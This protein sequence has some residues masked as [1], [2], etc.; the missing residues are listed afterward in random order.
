M[1]VIKNIPA[2]KEDGSIY[3]GDSGSAVEEIQTFLQTL[4]YITKQQELL[5]DM[6]I[7]GTPE[8]LT[9][10]KH[11]GQYDIE[12]RK[13]IRDYQ[14][15]N[16]DRIKKAGNLSDDE[17]TKME[18]SAIITYATG[19][20]L[21]EDMGK[22]VKP[23]EETK[24]KHDEEAVKADDPVPEPDTVA[25][26]PDSTFFVKTKNLQHR[27]A[28]RKAPAWVKVSKEAYEDEDKKGVRVDMM[29]NGTLLKVV[30]PHTGYQCEWHQVL[31]VD[32]DPKWDSVKELQKTQ[33]LYCY[34]EFV[35]GRPGTPP[36]PAIECMNCPEIVPDADRKEPFRDWTKIIEPE[37]NPFY[38]EPT[39]RW[40]IVVE[41]QQENTMEVELQEQRKLASFE[42]VRMLLEFFDK[43]SGKDVIDG[44]LQY[45]N[46]VED[47]DY[48][49][50]ERPGSRIK[51]LVGLPA[52][53]FNAVPRNPEYFEGI[54]TLG[55]IIQKQL[56]TVIIKYGDIKPGIEI[57]AKRF[58]EY[59]PEITSWSGQVLDYNIK[60]E[61]A[62]LRQFPKVFDD[63]IK[64][65]K[66]NQND[67][68]VY[69][70][71]F[72]GECFKF[73]Y[74]M[75]IGMPLRIGLECFKS[76]EP[77]VFERT[78]G[79]VF[80]LQDMV[81][82][83]KREKRRWIQFITDYTCPPVRIVPSGKDPRPQEDKVPEVPQK[84]Q[85]TTTEKKKEDEEIDKGR[86]TY[87][88][89][90]ETVLQYVGDPLLSC[91]NIYDVLK[92][93]NSIDDLYGKVLNRISLKSIISFVMSCLL[94]GL[95]LDE[96]KKMV[97]GFITK[98]LSFDKLQQFISYLDNSTFLKVQE[99]LL[100]ASSNP[101]YANV[102]P[103]I[104]LRSIL[105]STVSKG[106]ICDAMVKFDPE[107]FKFYFNKLVYPD[108]SEVKNLRKRFKVPTVRLKDFLPTEDTMREIRSA[109]E[110]VIKEA[111]LSVMLSLVKTLIDQMC[112]VCV[113]KGVPVG[114][115]PH[116]D[117]NI[118]DMIPPG[119]RTPVDDV[120]DESFRDF[121]NDLSALL[122]PME[123]CSLLEGNP[124]EEV[125]SVIK[126]LAKQ[127][128]PDLYVIFRE[129][130]K[131]KEVFSYLGRFVD[132]SLCASIRDRYVEPEDSLCEFRD[133]IKRELLQDKLTKEQLD[134]LIEQEK[135]RK[136]KLLESL[137]ELA[138]NEDILNDILPSL[139]GEKN[140]DKIHDFGLA[141]HDPPS[142][143]KL[144]D[145]VINMVFGNVEGCFNSD[146]RGYLD[147]LKITDS[148]EVS[149]LVQ[150]YKDLYDI[151]RKM[152]SGDNAITKEEQ[153]QRIA[154]LQNGTPSKV[155]VAPNFKNNLANGANFT[156]TSATNYLLK[157][158]EAISATK[159][160]NDLIEYL[161]SAAKI[162]TFQ[163]YNPKAPEKVET[164]EMCD[165]AIANIDTSVSGRMS[166]GYAVQYGLVKNEKQDTTVNFYCDVDNLTTPVTGSD[167]PQ[168]E[169]VEFSSK[170]K[171]N[172]FVP[173][174]AF[175]E[176]VN[177][178][179]A[180]NQIPGQILNEGKLK[181]Y[182]ADSASKQIVVRLLRKVSA[183]VSS[184]PMFDVNELNK[185]N[186]IGDAEIAD[187][188]CPKQKKSLLDIESIIEKVKELYEKEVQIKKDKLSA[189][190]LKM[191]PI[192]RANLYGV[193][194]AYVRVFVVEYLLR[195]LFVFSKFKVEDLV[196][197]PVL[198]Q[199]YVEKISV[200]IKDQSK[201]DYDFVLHY[202]KNIIIARGIT[203]I[204]DNTNDDWVSG[205][206]A[207]HYIVDE[208]ISSVASIFQELLVGF[209]KDNI[210]KDFLSSF[211]PVKELM[212][213]N[214]YEFQVDN[215][216]DF[217]LERY[218]RLCDDNEFGEVV[219]ET[220]KPVSNFKYVYGLRL[221][222][223]FGKDV[224]FKQDVFGIKT[225]PERYKKE[226]SY[227]A[228][229]FIKGQEDDFTGKAVKN[230]YCI[231]PL[232]F[233]EEGSYRVG[234]VSN[235]D[236]DKIVE[237]LK[238]KLIE[239]KEFGFL[240][241]Y[242]FPLS[243]YLSLMT[244]YS[245]VAI[246]LETT[247]IGD[248]FDGT[249][250]ALMNLVDI[251]RPSDAPWWRRGLK[252]IDA[253]G[254]NE[255]IRKEYMDNEKTNG[256][257]PNLAA[258]AARTVPIL[259]KGLAEKF[260]PNYGLMKKIWDILPDA[261]PGGLTWLS[262]PQF[263]PINF[264]P[265]FGWGP[266]LTTLGML[267][268]SVGLLPG[269][270]RHQAQSSQKE[271]T[272]QEEKCKKK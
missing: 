136:K 217:I 250:K 180:T 241:K 101:V 39:C 138:D 221:S 252:D 80:Y 116:G 183:L 4:P 242:V 19:L 107:L 240:F 79:Y 109:L 89:A 227:A 49:L 55:G 5:G 54:P 189:D 194:I 91:D 112:S 223:V 237:E 182:L 128:Y 149:K 74:A 37:C 218:V 187:I 203:Q 87:S 177:S 272:E 192:E 48:F 106:D 258:M 224:N 32:A 27:L 161:K 257:I 222:Y 171:S 174:G 85:K 113:K 53:Y 28:L 117:Q 130:S 93:V 75:T 31:V 77:I 59:A 46:V 17:Y 38:D 212:V 94:S 33:K 234:E 47:K 266:P 191:D 103:A 105:T 239:T 3:P 188:N 263:L 84:P 268:L 156:S 73:S 264:F 68:A 10:P 108:L 159:Q 1:S 122:T 76:K 25:Q 123:L 193:V 146:L 8:K 135:E 82:S 166:D 216:G 230:K 125:I 154:T 229:Y 271:K 249:K 186:L 148:V 260:D 2:S 185:T 6:G 184:S 67:D 88:K 13:A 190:Q 72:T 92:G 43:K 14:R 178:I 162:P 207:L 71:G 41:S 34:A 201:S 134:T 210:Y 57:I 155:L 167:V 143:S 36:L 120:S 196:S 24:E 141:P 50:S 195:G 244:I 63:F 118:N 111:L 259:I 60:E 262:V 214:E 163:I 150:Q 20:I 261:V 209:N 96:L 197:D 202:C 30:Y 231:T 176:Y 168:D 95:S 45:A 208:N 58:E 26:V 23:P 232:V 256:P 219:R 140:T 115:G 269:E 129:S 199:Y 160:V 9:D 265:L 139:T 254:G 44:I 179:W 267:A 78:M 151:D 114:D 213:Q 198:L 169:I 65:N 247:N 15:A 144:N 206:S 70:L 211:Y 245:D 181:K 100:A 66:A 64:L 121:L 152:S 127:K 83:I 124:S 236:R 175:A 98:K 126:G 145:D 147:L 61:V 119:M 104:K 99:E 22:S 29:P 173:H 233:V 52:K 90:R 153:D 137:F 18:L 102:D 132:K 86:L 164:V 248:A 97:C 165:V 226:R 11:F 157:H 158:T 238:D 7:G 12:T 62:R 253:R 270:Q 81:A 205:V 133:N 204:I 251:L 51:F 69:E 110:A 35:H 40:Y 170:Y 21:L 255:G 225:L 235:E 200:E 131:I 16:I 228:E 42:G 215:D 142:I 56:K 172:G 243:R 246:S 220:N